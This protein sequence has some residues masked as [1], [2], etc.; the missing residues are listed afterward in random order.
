VNVLLKTVLRGNA[1]VEQDPTDGQKN[2]GRNTPG[3]TSQT[4]GAYTYFSERDPA[5]WLADLLK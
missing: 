1:V 2:T 4:A 3:L 5:W